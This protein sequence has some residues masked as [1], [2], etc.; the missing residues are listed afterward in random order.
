MIRFI[1]MY[2]ADAK[3]VCGVGD[4]L[5][6]VVQSFLVE[7]QIVGSVSVGVDVS[8]LFPVSGGLRQG[9]LISQLLFNVYMDGVIRG[10]CY[11]AY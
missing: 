3:S 4:K 6:K 7:L 10:E 5:L 11:R 2:V 8:E 1:V 9:C